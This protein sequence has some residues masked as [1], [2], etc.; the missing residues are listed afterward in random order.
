MAT[1]QKEKEDEPMTQAEKD[2]VKG[3]EKRIEILEGA[4]NKIYHYTMEIPEWGRPTIQKLLD[5]GIYKGAS[6]ND[7]NLPHDMMRQ[8]VINDR[9]GMYD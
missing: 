6:D 9:S 1:W 3:L 8:F 4:Q 5:K 2:Y 7:L